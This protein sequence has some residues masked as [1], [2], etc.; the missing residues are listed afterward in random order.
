M[1]NSPAIPPTISCGYRVQHR[2]RPFGEIQRRAF[3][4]RLCWPVGP[5]TGRTG[6]AFGESILAKKNETVG[7]RTRKEKGRGQAPPSFTIQAHL[8]T[9]RFIACGPIVWRL[10]HQPR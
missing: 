10:A 5:E 3:G 2:N 1:K 4:A 7:A 8:C 6:D 9:A